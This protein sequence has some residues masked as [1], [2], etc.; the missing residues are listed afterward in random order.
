MLKYTDLKR[1]NRQNLR[2][3]LPLAKPF[4]L[5]VEPS[6]F[7]NFKCVQCFHSIAGDSGFACKQAN[8]GLDRFQKILDQVQ[9]WPGP[10]LKVLKLSLYGEPL[11]NPHFSRMLELARQADIAERIET[12]T[13]AS[14][15]TP[16]VAETMVRCQLDYIRV[17][18]YA[19]DQKRHEAVTGSHLDFQVI[20]ENL[21]ILQEIKRR[22]GS[23][24]PFVG[25]KMLDTYGPENDT[26]KNHYRDVA[27]EL[28]LD[29]PHSWIQVDGSD[30]IG[31]YYGAQQ[32]TVLEDLRARDSHRIA[33]PMAFTTMAVRAN[34]EVSPCCVDFIGGTSLG[35]MEDTELPAIWQGLPWYEFQKMQLQDR[36]HE[37]YACARCDIYR[38]DH[39]T[40]DNID[41]F[42]IDKLR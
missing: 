14:L 1:T 35:N 15:L 39:Y 32:D 7:C 27:D 17:S 9:A 28:Y 16:Q 30:F 20:H 42:P 21:R 19:A 2:D 11:V 22:E 29:K 10:R 36:K 40:L 37:N 6:S 41:G 33:C 3:V 4:T 8:M 24:K 23:A 31:G 5:L 38:N 34:G 18:I 26:F 25:C 12:T 13:N